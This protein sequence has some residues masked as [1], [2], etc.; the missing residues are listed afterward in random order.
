MHDLSR[1]TRISRPG[2]PLLLGLLL[3]LTGFGAGIGIARQPD[4][5]STDQPAATA[6]SALRTAPARRTFHA[7][8]PLPALGRTPK[9]PRPDPQPAVPPPPSGNVPP[10]APFAPSPTEPKTGPAGPLH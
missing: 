8:E 6:V 5:S 4:K 7:A 10:S 2:R 1:L 9:R 3:C